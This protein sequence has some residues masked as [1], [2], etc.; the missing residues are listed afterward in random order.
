M[1]EEKITN[2]NAS[3]TIYGFAFQRDAAIVIMLE[4]IKD[5]ES[6][7]L[8]GN[9]EDIELKL[10][11]GDYIFA[12][13]K[14]MINA[15]AHFDR[16]RS[17]LKDALQSL[18]NTQV[19][20][21]KERLKVKQYI[22]VSNIQNPFN[23]KHANML[24]NPYGKKCY[25]QL[26]KEL[27]TIIDENLKDVIENF[28]KEKLYIQAFPYDGDIESGE[29]L[30]FVYDKIKE[31]LVDCDSNLQ[32]QYKRLYDSWTNTVFLNGMESNVRKYISKERIVWQIIS[33]VTEQAVIDNSLSD[34]FQSD[35]YE[36]I[37]SRYKS[38]IDSSSNCFSLV[39]KIISDFLE[40]VYSGSTKARISNFINS[41]WENY[42]DELP[43]GILDDISLECLVKVLLYKVISKREIIGKL[44]ERTS[45]K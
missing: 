44:K 9:Y 2:K 43:K 13:A 40:F 27:C 35:V 28:E 39:T 38:I 4:F 14:S 30:K 36:N 3:S 25:L 7:R 1:S 15:I 24:F 42:Q 29:C 6:I 5:M 33:L 23:H 19:K 34:T 22:Y 32:Y 17:K 16:A 31:F 18:A 41:S 26:S 8:E 11:N 20:A 21:D 45:L 12:Q 10:S 37:I